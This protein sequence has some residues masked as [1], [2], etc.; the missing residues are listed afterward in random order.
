VDLTNRSS[1]YQ[2]QPVLNARRVDRLGYLRVLGGIAMMYRGSRVS[3]GI[4]FER[5]L[6]ILERQLSKFAV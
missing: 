1:N 2:Q 5:T 6:D 4:V 3:D